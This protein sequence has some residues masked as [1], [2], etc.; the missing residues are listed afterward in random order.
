MLQILAQESLTKDF[1]LRSQAM[2]R[3]DVGK[4]LTV[5][6]PELDELDQAGVIL[7]PSSLQHDRSEMVSAQHTSWRRTELHLDRLRKRF[8]GQLIVHLAR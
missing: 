6:D 3:L 1:P 8:I 2:A 4:S 5:Q 7:G